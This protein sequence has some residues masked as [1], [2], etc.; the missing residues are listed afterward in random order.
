[1]GCNTITLADGARAIVCSRSKRGQ[2]RCEWCAK[3]ALY[4]CDGPAG[5]RSNK[6]TCSAHMCG[7]HRTNVGADRDLCP[8]HAADAPRQE[9]LL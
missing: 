6:R 2:R 4:Q 1:M 8:R 9:A 7:E 3:E 5:G